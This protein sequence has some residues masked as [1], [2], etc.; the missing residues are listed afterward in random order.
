MEMV[1]VVCLK[2]GDAYSPEYV[3]KLYSMVSRHLTL[4]FRFICFTENQDNIRREVEL[5]PLPDFQEPPA[6]Y[7]RYCQAWRKLALFQSG[8]A[9]MQGKVLFLDLDVVIMDNIDCFFAYSDKLAII[10]NWFQPG[11][12]VGQASAICFTAGKEELLLKHYM[13]NT[14][15]VLNSYRT[16]QAY[17]TG[18]LSEGGFAFF[19]Q[20]WCVSFKKHCMP[21]GVL[22]FFSSKVTEPK[23]AKIVVFHGRPN[24][25]DAIEGRWGKVLPWYKKWYK[26]V[27]PSQW[28]ADNWR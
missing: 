26:R 15:Q 6:E 11:Q 19:P 4:P 27:Q 25:P 20:D 24:P 2:W 9:D 1:N 16:E 8:L 5:W 10:E 23:S 14:E 17:I 13:E 7:L 3:N 22:R 28:V 18:F 12:L 21:S